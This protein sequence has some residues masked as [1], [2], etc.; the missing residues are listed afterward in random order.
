MP[1]TPCKS[2]DCEPLPGRHVRVGDSEMWVVEHGAGP[3]V[4]LVHGVPTTSYLWRHVQRRLADTCRTIAVD[5]LG[6]GRSRHG[7]HPLDL[8]S[9]ADALALLCRKLNLERVHVVG[10][11]VGGGVV[12]HLVQRHRARVR[13]VVLCDVVAFSRSWPV[14]SV[15]L[16]RIP[17][18]GEVAMILGPFRTVLDSQLARGLWPRRRLGADVLDRYYEPLRSLAARLRFL[19]LLR[20]LDPPAVERALPS[21]GSMPVRVV[22]GE[23]DVFQPVVEARALAAA[24]PAAA[25]RVVS[26]GHFLPEDKPAVL[27]EEIVHALTNLAVAPLDTRR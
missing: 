6:A 16:L 17:G 4:L 22:W 10:H 12:H 23:Q 2:P 18:L 5:L 26:G 27:V 19:A 9:Q 25:L 8:A 14:A 21:Y 7:S 24:L 3:P 13:G 20:A 15:E 11:D 1:P